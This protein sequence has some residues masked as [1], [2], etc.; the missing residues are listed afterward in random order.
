MQI[1]LNLLA[2]VALLV[3]GTH[4]VRQSILR[5]Y[6]ANLRNILGRSIRN[7]FSA[8]FAGIGVTA[9]VQSSTATALIAASFVSQ[10]LMATAPAL[11][12]ML[13]AD[14]GTSLVVQFF[15]LDL[16]WL[17][18]LLIFAGV[19]LYLSQQSNTAGRLGQTAIGL[20]LII[21][22][23]QLIMQATHP[24]TQAAGVK[25]IFGSL[26]GDSA[27]DM[28]IGALFSIICYSSLATVLL[29]AA[30]AGAHVV[31]TKV[32]LCLVLGANLGGGILAVLTTL[33]MSHEGRRIPL[34][35]LVFKVTGCIVI[36]PLIVWI[37][38]LLR[39]IGAGPERMAVNFHTLFNLLIAIGFIYATEPVA[40]LAEKILPGVAEKDDPARPRHLDPSA[41]DSPALAISCAAREALRLGDVVETMIR[42]IRPVLLHND[43][44]RAEEV[45]RM[46]DIVDKLQTAIKLYLT[47]INHDA[48]DDRE[49]RRI[50]EIVSFAINMEHVGDIVEHILVDLEEKKSRKHLTFSEAGLAEICDLHA[51]LLANLQLGLS[52]FLNGELRSAERLIAEKQK[53]R[54]LSLTYADNHIRRLVENTRQSIETSSLHLD[55][56]SDLKRINSLICSI[57]YPILEAAGVLSPTR[58]RDDAAPESDTHDTPK[59]GMERKETRL[60]RDAT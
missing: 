17:S 52:V 1:L 42:G 26:T 59:K 16:S 36:L 33:G 2:G 11:A 55:I 20:G 30:L 28:L 48:L 8:F 6:G 18:P 25:V 29:T 15:S 47:Q 24:L 10:K 58:L 44:K 57:A 53:F 35:N 34:G 54:D 21:L 9:L 3:W 32:A 43:L 46:D 27:L 51:R 56:L 41:L 45:R 60:R 13:G 38:P 49:S 39:V 4:I 14:V 7:R 37:E 50:T 22:A 31:S 5:V 40:R 23:L 12:I 19:V